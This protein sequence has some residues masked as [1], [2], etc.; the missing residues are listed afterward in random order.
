APAITAPAEGAEYLLEQDAHQQLMLACNADNEVTAVNWYI[1]NK[2]YASAS[3][4][5][6][7]FFEP[8]AGIIK[9]SCTDDQGRN[10]NVMIE[11]KYL[12]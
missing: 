8:E 1:N 12:E 3:A 2:F 5:D 7:I 6:K 4:H 11:V 10:S 9:I